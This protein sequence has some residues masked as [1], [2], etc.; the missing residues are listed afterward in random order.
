MVWRTLPLAEL[1]LLLA[2]GVGWR[3][4]LQRR[5]T[6]SAGIV[7]FRSG[8]VP[9]LRDSALVVLNVVLAVEAGLTLAGPIPAAPAP[10]A[11]VGAA[12]AALGTALM[13]W[14]QLDLGASWR[15]GIE[16]GV[17]PGLVT[18]RWYRVSRNPIFLFMF[19][20][21]GGLA[22]QMPTAVSAV[23]FAA[24]CVGIRWHVVH[25]EEPWLTRTYGDAYRAYGRR[26]GRFVPWLGRFPAADG[27]DVRAVRP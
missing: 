24:L 8:G 23:L 4:W 25:Q 26:V 10:W 2:I 18:R 15:I 6:G 3:A 17:R 21:Y 19:L 1:I 22:I 7:L 16:E 12:L 14:A 5:R 9:A 20:A 27:P 11:A 13:A